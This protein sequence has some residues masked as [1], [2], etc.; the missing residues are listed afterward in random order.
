MLVFCLSEIA[1]HVGG[2]AEKDQAPAFVEQDRLMKHL[3]NLRARLM[4]RDDNDFV[5]RH[6]PN[7]FH[8]VLRIL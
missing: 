6:A 3:E 7:D 4:N 2:R 1:E 8:D 5:V